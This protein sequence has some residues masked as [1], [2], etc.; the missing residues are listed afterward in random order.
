MNIDVCENSFV[1]TLE[2][3]IGPQ[4]AKGDRGNGIADVTYNSASHS[5]TFTDDD[6]R[7]YS[8]GS[9]QGDKGDTGDTGVG[10]EDAELNQDYTLTI[11]LTNGETF[12]TPP[13]RGEKGDK[14]D[15]GDTGDSYTFTD[16]NHDGH[17]VITAGGG[18]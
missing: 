14:G 9:L 5:L 6:G 13:I 12:T 8:T 15:K 11:T 17:I 3:G 16:A 2:E 10:V 18:I 7:E 1:I 4:G